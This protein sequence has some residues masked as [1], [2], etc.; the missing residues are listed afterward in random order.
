[1]FFF[2]GTDVSHKKHSI[3]FMFTV[4]MCASQ[5]SK[6]LKDSI[7]GMQMAWLPAEA[8]GA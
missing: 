7:S 1:M 3:R 6:S 8:F 4:K 2:G 5:G